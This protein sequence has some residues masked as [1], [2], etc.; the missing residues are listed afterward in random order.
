M[1]RIVPPLLSGI[2]LVAIAGCGNSD[3]PAAENAVPQAD[4]KQIDKNIEEQMKKRMNMPPSN[5]PPGSGD[6]K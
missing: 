2:L 4:K 1:S 5:S 6:T 3:K